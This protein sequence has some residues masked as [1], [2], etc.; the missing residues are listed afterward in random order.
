MHSWPGDY[1]TAVKVED[2]ARESN[3][4]T[5]IARRGAASATSRMKKRGAKCPATWTK[6]ADAIL[7]SIRRFWERTSDSGH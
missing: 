5:H 6:S 4:S 1:A 7:A 3:A 2:D